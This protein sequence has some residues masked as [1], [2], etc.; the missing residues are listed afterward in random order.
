MSRLGGSDYTRGSELL[1]S[2]RYNRFFDESLILANIEYRYSIYEYGDFAGDAVG[3][4]DIGEV[5]DELG[6]F[7][8]DE[9]KFSYGGGVNVKFRRNTLLS[10]L[11][12]RGNEGWEFATR[13]KVAF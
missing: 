10:L 1:R 7:G 9:L 5:F 2:Y 12:A 3:L 13:T 4:F 6:H 8:F 11:A